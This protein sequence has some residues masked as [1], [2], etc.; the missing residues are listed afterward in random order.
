MAPPGRIVATFSVTTPLFLGDAQR[1]ATRLSLQSLKGALRFWWRALAWQDCLDEAGGNRAAALKE[2]HR[3]EARIFGTAGE[4]GESRKGLGQAR[5]R[6]AIAAEALGRPLLRGEKLDPGWGGR[7]LG[8]GLMGA[9]GKNAGVLD[10]SCFPAGG[11]FRVALGFHEDLEEAERRSVLD[12]LKLL[13]LLGGI[14]ARTRRGFGSLG[15]EALDGEAWS[16]PP[17]VG[18]YEQALKQIVGRRTAPLPPFSAFSS[19]SRI[20]LLATG[21]DPL[22]LLDAV[23]QAMVRYRAW[24]FN[25][26]LPSGEPALQRF[27]ED[28]DWAKAPWT[29][30][31]Q[32]YVPKRVAFGLPHNYGPKCHNAGVTTTGAGQAGDRRGSPL[33]I[34]IQDLGAGGFAAVSVFLPADFTPDGRVRVNWDRGGYDAQVPRDWRQT[35]TGLLEGDFERD[36]QRRKFFPDR[37]KVLP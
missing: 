14:G 23:G 2:L 37:R 18:A 8:Y 22:A 26:K 9:F 35:L 15:L 1:E 32:G 17:S 20:D 7:Y 21:P 19:E 34:H 25:G 16:K 3:R 6:L 10:R 29:G 30:E 36:G 5:V 28:H 12:A 31:G 24:G 33:L 4:A 11:R 13:G 27:R